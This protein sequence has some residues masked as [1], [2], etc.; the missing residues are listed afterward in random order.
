MYVSIPAA[1]AIP[2]GGFSTNPNIVTAGT[3]QYDPRGNFAA[4]LYTVPVTGLYRISVALSVSG[5]L[6]SDAARS[7]I[8]K[9][10]GSLISNAR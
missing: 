9:A 10:G 6:A 8:E 3:A 2:N 7:A 1:T 5:V 4:G